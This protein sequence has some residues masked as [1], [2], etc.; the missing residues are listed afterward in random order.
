MAKLIPIKCPSCNSNLDVGE[1]KKYVTCQ[2]CN[3]RVLVDDGIKRIELSFA[4]SNKDDIEIV[5]NH[6]KVG[7]ILDAAALSTNLL[8]DSPYDMELLK[9]FIETRIKYI[10]SLL[11][12]KKNI[13]ID[14]EKFIRS[15]S[16]KKDDML[17]IKTNIEL[18]LEKLEIIE[19]LDAKPNKKYIEEKK[20][21]LKSLSIPV[22]NLIKQI[23]DRI[24][25][26]K[27]KDENIKI[28]KTIIIVVIVIF[29]YIMITLAIHNLF[30]GL[31]E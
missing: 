24:E 20:N 14:K 21:E 3:T 23:E 15:L 30:D 11:D 18:C 6:L 12:E 22:D 26:I 4:N 25:S 29:V 31:F 17:L 5:K 28:I 16:S 19:K 9:L 13:N 2:Y 8:E 7:K 27:N 1:N 10:N